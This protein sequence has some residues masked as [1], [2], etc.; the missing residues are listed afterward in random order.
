MRKL[1]ALLILMFVV[2][3]A[4]GIL[5]SLIAGGSAALR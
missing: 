2:P 4:I 1:L 3:V 5:G